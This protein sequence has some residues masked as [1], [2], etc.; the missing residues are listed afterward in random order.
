MG[1]ISDLR[2]TPHEVGFLARGPFGN[3]II[4][5]FFPVVLMFNRKS[6]P[7]EREFLQRYCPSTAEGQS[8]EKWEN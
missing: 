6:L 3:L 1:K 4:L 8:D 2:I 5:D 7:F